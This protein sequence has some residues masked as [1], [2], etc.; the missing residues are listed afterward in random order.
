MR[1][2]RGNSLS[3]TSIELRWDPPTGD[4]PVGYYRIIYSIDE[5]NARASTATSVH[6]S[7]ED[8]DHLDDD[9][10]GDETEIQ[11]W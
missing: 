11:V 2:F 3:S 9:E 7:D 8:D 1:N 10:T 6:H 5:E 4:E